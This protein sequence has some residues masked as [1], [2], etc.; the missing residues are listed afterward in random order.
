LS[1]KNDLISIKNIKFNNIFLDCCNFPPD[2]FSF[3]NKNDKYWDIIA[4]L[5]PVYFKRL[6]FFLDTIKKLF[7]KSGPKKVLCIVPFTSGFESI[8]NVTN[9]SL[10]KVMEYFKKNFSEEERKFINFITTKYDNS[11]FDLKTLSF[12]Y[13]HSKIFIHPSAIE[14]RPRI[15]AYAF[16][17]G[18]P[19]VSRKNPASILPPYLQKKPFLFLV[20]KDSDFV[21]KILDALKF[22]NSSDYNLKRMKNVMHYFNEK[23]NKKILIKK[24]T[25]SFKIS[26]SNNIIKSFKLNNLDFRLGHSHLSKKKNHILMI[27][28]SLYLQLKSNKEQKLNFDENQF[29]I[30]LYNMNYIIFLIFDFFNMIKNFSYLFV[31][32]LLRSVFRKVIQ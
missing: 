15:S 14:R 30:I 17:A 27:L 25:S 11:P 29:N 19:V 1:G 28:E 10:N 23:N 22:V 20:N 9:Y 32:Y 13:Q 4:V 31:I 16:K 8:F 18:L 5:R 24:L 2:C 6:F 7:D 12:F 21:K 26:L 3:K